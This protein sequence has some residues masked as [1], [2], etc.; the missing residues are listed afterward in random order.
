MKH[1][2]KHSDT[3]E[4]NFQITFSDKGTPNSAIGSEPD[5]DEVT[6]VVPAKGK[7]DTAWIHAFQLMALNGRVG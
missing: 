1:N 5:K 4:G 7:S 3:S 2:K 6:N